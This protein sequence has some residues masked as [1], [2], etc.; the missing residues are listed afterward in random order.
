[1][2]VYGNT[3]I[4]ELLLVRNV[5]I[6]DSLTTGKCLLNALQEIWFCEVQFYLKLNLFWC[7]SVYGIML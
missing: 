6:R 4:V 2:Y 5:N 1:M 7:T 3:C